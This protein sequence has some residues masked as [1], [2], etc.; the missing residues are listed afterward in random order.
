MVARLHGVAVDS[1]SLVHQLAFTD[2]ANADFDILQLAAQKLNLKARVETVALNR[3]RYTPLPAI[4]QFQDGSWVMVAAAIAKAQDPTLN[5]PV[6]LKGAALRAEVIAQQ[7]G[8]VGS[9]V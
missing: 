7:N 4:T 8:Q 3:L 6:D 1:T 5:P 9:Y 2:D